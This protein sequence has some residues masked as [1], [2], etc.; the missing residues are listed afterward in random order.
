MAL[1]FQI[2]R[3]ASAFK[4]FM[5]AVHVTTANEA[6][7]LDPYLVQMED[8]VTQFLTAE[9]A[10]CQGLRIYAI[11]HA[12]SEKQFGEESILSM[13]PM[14]AT[15]FNIKNQFE[16][17]MHLATNTFPILCTSIALNCISRTPILPIQMEARIKT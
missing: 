3:K 13:M 7:Q 1:G 5:Q 11:L 6:D 2:E 15:S 4:N 8:F 10:Q 16:I 14:A 9:I 12:L 17:P